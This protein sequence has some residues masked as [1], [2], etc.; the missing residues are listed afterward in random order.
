M[1]YLL[2]VRGRAVH[3]TPKLT[4]AQSRRR[5]GRSVERLVGIG[6]RRSD[7]LLDTVS[8]LINVLSVINFVATSGATGL[9]S[10]QR[11]LGLISK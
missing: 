5:S 6:A 8:G 7:Y 4:G 1:L 9:I 3:L 10:A 11:I 2:I